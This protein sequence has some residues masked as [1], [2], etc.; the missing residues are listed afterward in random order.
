MYKFSRQK[1]HELTD[2]CIKLK[3]I[4]IEENWKDCSDIEKIVQ[5][6]NR[7]FRQLK[8]KNGIGQGLGTEESHANCKLVCETRPRLAERCIR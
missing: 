3:A 6:L 1:Q 2:A 4:L 8:L 7:L 5:T